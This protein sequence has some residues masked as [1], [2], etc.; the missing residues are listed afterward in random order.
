MSILVVLSPEQNDKIEALIKEKFSN[1]HYTI[2]PNQWLVSSSKT[3]R[4]LAEEDLLVKD[5][6][7]GPGTIIVFA[8]SG[9]W[10]RANPDIWKWIEDKWE[11]H[12]G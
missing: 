7:K 1:D 2:A 4:Q 5:K 9:Y 12:D 6:E 3:A 10:G 8:I 11:E